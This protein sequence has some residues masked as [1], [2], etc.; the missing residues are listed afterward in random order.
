MAIGECNNPG[1]DAILGL[2]HES[3]ARS[4]IERQ[5]SSLPRSRFGQGGENSLV[6]HLSG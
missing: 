2:N 4:P 5:G 3:N 6:P 1:P